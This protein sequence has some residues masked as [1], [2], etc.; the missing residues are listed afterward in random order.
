MVGG[1]SATGASSTCLWGI[2]VP[3]ARRATE[4]LASASELGPYRLIRS[5]GRGGMAEVFLAVHRHLGQVRAVKVLLPD[6][7]ATDL[8]LRLITE[9][10]AMSRLRHR[11]IVEVYECDTLPSHGAFMAMEHLAGESVSEWLRRCGSLEQ[12]PTLAAAL[13]GVVADALAYA[14]EHGIVHRDIKPGNLFVVPD[15]VGGGRFRVK[16]LDFGIAKLLGEEPLVATR[17]GSVVG[18]PFYLPPEGWYTGGNIDARTDIYSLGCVF[19]ELL[20]GRPPFLGDDSF[21]LM[22]AHLNQAAPSLTAL[23]PT[24]PTELAQ[25]VARMLAKDPGDRPDSMVEVVRALEA[26]LG[27][28]RE[29]F[30]ERLLAPAELAIETGEGVE[31]PAELAPAHRPRNS[32]TLV[33]E[34]VALPARRGRLSARELRILVGASLFS[35]MAG[36]AALGPA[37]FRSRGPVPA[38]PPATSAAPPVPPPVQAAE[39][40]PASPLSPGDSLVSA[41]PGAQPAAP[42]PRSQRRARTAEPA[43]TQAYQG[44]NHYLPV[45]D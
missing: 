34:V 8:A 9:A 40:V 17:M 23:S 28:G 1:Q 41:A 26:F 36:I 10:R 14:H 45:E 39:P 30:A 24:V 18:T 32:A 22:N 15:P 43:R 21:Q 37:L 12:H 4:T 33:G 44:L 3:S 27:C 6:A 38:L 20:S 31:G 25:L 7:T 35:L 5:L 11:A 13:V 2:G 29:R 42:A 19:F 16:V